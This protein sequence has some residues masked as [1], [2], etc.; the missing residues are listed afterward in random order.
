MWRGGPDLAGVTLESLL[1]MAH[2]EFVC[3]AAHL[4][5]TAQPGAILDAKVAGYVEI[6]RFASG[7]L[8]VFRKVAVEPKVD[9]ENI[10]ARFSQNG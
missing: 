8:L 1:T 4:G 2:L 7:R 5:R 3:A 10:D 6:S 9:R